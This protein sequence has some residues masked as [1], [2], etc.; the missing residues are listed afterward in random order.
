MESKDLEAEIHPLKNE[1]GKGPEGLANCTQKEAAPKKLKRLSRW[2]TA[3][4]FLSLFLCLTVVFA[5]S[6]I[7]PCPVRPISQRMWSRTYED[8]AT[9]AFLAMQDVNKDR[10]QDVLFAFK[11]ASAGSNSTNSSCSSQG[12]A[13]PCAFLAAHSGTNGSTLWQRP[14]AQELLLMDCSGEQDHSPACLIVGEPDILAAIDLETGQTLWNEAAD[15]GP[16]STVLSPLLKIPDVN[17]D[18][19][20]DLLVFAETGEEIQAHFYSGKHGTQIGSVGTLHLP[21]RVGHLMQVTPKGSHYVL[22]YTAKALYGYSLKALCQMAFSSPAHSSSGLTE[23]P[24]WETAIN[25]ATRQITLLSTGEIRYLTKMPVSSS[26][27]FLVSRS[28]MLELVDGRH[29]GSMWVTET[30]HIL[31][32]PVLGAYR[33]D[34]VDVIVTSRDSSGKKVMVMEGTSGDIEWEASLQLLS[35][36]DSPRPATLSTLDRRSVFLFWGLYQRDANGTGSWDGAQQQLYLFHP[37]LPNV[38]LETSNVTEHIVAFEGVLFERSRHAC[39][40]LLTGPQVGQAPGQVMLSKWKL[41]EAIA[42]SRVI[43]LNQVAQNS[44]QSVRERFLRMRYRS[45]Q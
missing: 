5:F 9:Y 31:S 18:S 6:F 8:A 13:S 33:P 39:Y 26:A 41:K 16:N 10:V 38:L 7:I 14:V 37:A 25:S 23:D 40:V 17:G 29:L 45:P 30:P 19:T 42:G 32:E 21:G 22:L 2:R 11:A 3:A 34:E 28:N 27:D 1:E 43:W 12:L 15:L 36:A 35:G 20:S 4:F 44:E 24:L